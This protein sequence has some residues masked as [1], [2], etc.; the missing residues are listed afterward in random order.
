MS[1]VIGSGLS[2]SRGRRS[3]HLGSVRLFIRLVFQSHAHLSKPPE[4]TW[5]DASSTALCWIKL[6]S[7]AHMSG[8]CLIL[9]FMAELCLFSKNVLKFLLKFD[10]QSMYKKHTSVINSKCTTTKVQSVR[11]FEHFF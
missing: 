4:T 3:G 9:P 10:P 11:I 8:V 5:A 1:P 2:E 7:L 6:Q